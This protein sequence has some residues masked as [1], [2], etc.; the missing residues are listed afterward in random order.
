MSAASLYLCNIN[1]SFLSGRLFRVRVNESY[2]DYCPIEFCVP[3]GSLLSPTLFSIFINDL[4]DLSSPKRVYAP[5]FAD[6]IAHFLIYSGSKKISNT[7]NKQS[8]RMQ[9]WIKKWRLCMAVNKC[10]YI[11]YN[12]TLI[13]QEEANRSSQKKR[14]F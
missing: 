5:I 2:S 1:K 10:S 6:D 13:R 4:P 9:E 8:A 7:I 12:T 14:G 11:F 3:Q